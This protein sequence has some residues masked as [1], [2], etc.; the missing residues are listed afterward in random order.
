[1]P[2]GR[3][4]HRGHRSSMGSASRHA[5]EVRRRILTA[6]LAAGVASGG[7]ST[8]HAM[9]TGR[10]VLASTRAAGTLL[11]R[12]SL[13][14]GV[15]AHAVLTAGWTTV[16]ALGLPVRRRAR[17]GAAAGL[18][19]GALDLTIARHRFPAIAELPAGAQLADHVAF[20]VIVAALTPRVG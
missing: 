1:M 14:R 13:A 2:V 8:I 4:L 17:W 9:A 6:A 15:L 7:P 20:G 10:P 19:I 5:D 16:L 11:G 18:A 12:P 3:R